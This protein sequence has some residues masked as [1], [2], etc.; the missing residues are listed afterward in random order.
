MARFPTRNHAAR[1]P[2]THMIFS[3]PFSFILPFNPSTP[4]SIAAF[5]A[6]TTSSDMSSANSRIP[7]RTRVRENDE[8][9]SKKRERSA[10]E[11]EEHPAKVS[12]DSVSIQGSWPVDD[13][14][15][16]LHEPR[17]IEN[18]VILPKMRY[19]E[20]LLTFE[21]LHN[22]VEPFSEEEKEFDEVDKSS[23]EKSSTEEESG[24]EEES[25]TEKESSTKEE[26]GTEEEIDS[27][28]EGDEEQ[29]DQEEGSLSEREVRHENVDLGREK[30]T[31][32]C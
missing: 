32:E 14:H 25:S 7:D 26:S 6:I 22:N 12:T 19:G 18:V 2:S 17:I 3:P 5:I 11:E 23:G 30:D 8:G 15:K 1:R 21:E 31:N 9:R 4:S 28:E 10:D 29:A 13:T 27:N 20:H 16:R 24:T